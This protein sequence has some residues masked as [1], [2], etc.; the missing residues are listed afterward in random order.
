MVNTY[1]INRWF[2]FPLLLAEMLFFAACQRSTP[3]RSALPFGSVDTPTPKTV[4]QGQFQVAGWA[5]S[6]QPIEA[7]SIY[8]D[9]K[10][11]GDAQV[12]LARPDVAAAHAGYQDASNAGWTT[13]LEAASF[14]PGWH[15]LVVQARSQDGAT[16]IWPRF[17]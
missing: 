10:Y 5:L 15:E 12:K 8:I 2:A 17:R 16:R 4:V 1:P 6:E 13:T 7:V 3:K 14:T 9:R 11:L